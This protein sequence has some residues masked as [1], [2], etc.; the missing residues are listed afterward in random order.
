MT[1]E[2]QATRHNVRS[3]ETATIFDGAG[4]VLYSGGQSLEDASTM[5]ELDEIG[6]ILIGEDGH[7]QMIITLNGERSSWYVW[8]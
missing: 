1:Y 4:S 7:G 5:A 6:R 8:G 3:W 2:N